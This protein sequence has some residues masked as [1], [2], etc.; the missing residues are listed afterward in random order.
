VFTTKPA[1]SLS[2]S[3]PLLSLSELEEGFFLSS[4]NLF[5]RGS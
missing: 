4:R 2:L 3:L 5:L 1:L